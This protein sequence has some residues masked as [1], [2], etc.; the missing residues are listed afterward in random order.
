MGSYKGD[1]AVQNPAAAT[2]KF[3]I[4]TDAVSGDTIHLVL[5]VVDD[6]A[7]QLTTY[8]RTIITVL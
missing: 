2:T 3:F 7:P 1:V 8:L 6:G 4:P 5:T